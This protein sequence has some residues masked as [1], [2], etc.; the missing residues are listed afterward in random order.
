MSISLFEISTEYRAA[1]LALADS[2]LDD[3][4]IDDTLEGMAGELVDKGRNVAAFCLNLSAEV[5]AIHAVEKRIVAKRKALEAKQDRLKEYLK[6]NMARCGITEI[7]ANDHSFKAKLYIGR[8]VSVV[9]DGDVPADY[10]REIP[11]KFEPDKALIKKAIND[12]ATVAG[13]HIEK[14]DRL[15]IK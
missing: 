8:D 9:I 5:E 7:V 6:V 2:D 13:A 14:R 4:T 15:E 3:T 12:G 10:L 11:A 1:F